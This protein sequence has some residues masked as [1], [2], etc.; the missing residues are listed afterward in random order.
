MFTFFYFVREY[1]ERKGD[2]GGA[3][4]TNVLGRMSPEE[5]PADPDNPV[6]SEWVKEGALEKFNPPQRVEEPPVQ[7]TEPRKASRTKPPALPKLVHLYRSADG[8]LAAVDPPTVP[9]RLP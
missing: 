8:K 2:D 7:A 9:T 5:I 3:E 6:I 1:R 4:S